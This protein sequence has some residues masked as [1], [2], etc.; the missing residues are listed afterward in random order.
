LGHQREKM[1]AMKLPHGFVYAFG[2]LEQAIEELVGAGEI[3]ERLGTAS[4]TLAPIVPEDFPDHLRGEYASILEA[5][6]WVPPEEGSRQGLLGATLDAMAEEEAD[7]LAK[8]L[9]SFYTDAA[10][11]VYGRSGG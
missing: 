8:R 3:K 11:L 9:F 2:K 10:E 4:L 7:T 6:T 1:V 5:L